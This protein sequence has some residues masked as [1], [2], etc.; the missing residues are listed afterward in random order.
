MRWD[1]GAIMLLAALG[2]GLATHAWLRENPGSNPWA[3][4]DLRD[5][6][7]W[8]TSFKIADLRDD[9]A[10]CR[11]VLDRSGVPFTVLAATGEGA[12]RRADRTVL[13]QSPLSPAKPPTTCAVAAAFQLWIDQG[14]KPASL[15]IFG[16]PVQ[17]I[18]HFGAYNCRRLYGRNEGPWSEHA[19]GNAID[20]AAFVLAD[21]T[22]I[23]VLSDWAGEDK[24]AE[25]MRRIRDAACRS[26]GTVLSPD[27]NKAHADH[28]HLDQE[29]RGI[30]GVCR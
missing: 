24:K 18:Q 26:F 15:E 2:F 14:V 10:Q 5:A 9:P 20:I 11:A 6:E 27:Y 22:R 16:Q 7:G 23:S 3:P 28:L 19:T 1:R 4:L 25:F 17:R 21:R 12:C 8:A 30:G 29:Q 13:V